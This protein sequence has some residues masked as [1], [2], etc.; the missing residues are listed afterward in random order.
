MVVVI[1][2]TD[3]PGRRCGPHEDV[4]VGLACRGVKA[5]GVAV[6][7]RPW[8]VVGL[9]PG[10]APDARWECEVTVRTA[11]GQPPF[12]FGGP[13]V[14]GNRG[15]RNLG[16][17]WVD[18]LPDGT[19]ELFR[20]AKLRLQAVEPDLIRAAER[21]GHRLV[22]RLGLTGPRG[23]PRTASVRFPDLVWSAEPL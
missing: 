22:A 18:R 4:H 16:L 7:G 1:E 10:D 17:A 9:V 14:Q 5:P 21:P 11:V 20:G 23:G 6:P 2:A 13:Y 8:K 3:L 15:D 19:V 12:D